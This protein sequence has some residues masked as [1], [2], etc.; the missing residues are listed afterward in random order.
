MQEVG[1]V[2]RSSDELQRM[3][4]IDK[5]CDAAAARPALRLPVLRLLARRTSER[6][7]VRVLM[8]RALTNVVFKARNELDML[9]DLVLRCMKVRSTER[10]VTGDARSRCQ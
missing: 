1:R 3:H 9:A 7:S 6:N 10:T 5:L 8:M 2:L 4:A